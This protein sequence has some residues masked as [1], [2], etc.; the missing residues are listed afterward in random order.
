MKISI[1]TPTNNS[2]K[3]I[4]RNVESVVSQTFKNFE[5]VI[6]D[7][8]SN[9]NTL[10]LVKTSYTDAGL[11]NNLKIISEKDFGIS[12]AFNKGIK[13][14][15]GELIGILNS[16]DHYF[17]DSILNRVIAEF[18][19]ENILFVHGN[20]FFI[21]DIYGSNVRLPLLCPITKAMPFNHATMFF[22][23]SVYEKFGMF[24]TSFKHAMD[25]EFI[26]R[27][28]RQI[29]EFRNKGK[30]ISDDTLVVMS[31]GGSSWENEL[32]SVREVKHALKMHDVWN[33]HAILSYSFRIFRI[34]I[35]SLLTQLK[36]NR[37]VHFW[38]SVKWFNH[39]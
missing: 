6:I 34:K 16:D 30:Y 23:K 20:I 29:P 26:C 11:S 3:T 39:D 36:L 27:L 14:S 9:D 17:N 21:D 2:E 22:R 1:I 18:D 32:E 28:E 35:K 12:D 15:S 13:N 33:Y 25:F 5:Q 31:S 37:L 7:N 10:Q 38:R 24:D 4:V 8:L 19:D